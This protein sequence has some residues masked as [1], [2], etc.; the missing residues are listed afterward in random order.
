MKNSSRPYGQQLDTVLDSL[1]DGFCVFDREWRVL[2][3]NAPGEELLGRKVHDIQGK[4]FWKEFPTI[5]N[6]PFHL[7]CL[8]AAESQVKAEYEHYYSRTEKWFEINIYPAPESTTVYARDISRRK[9]VELANRQLVSQLERERT[10]LQTI[11][12]LLPIAVAVVEAPSGKL[13]YGNEQVSRIWRTPLQ[14]PAAIEEFTGWEGFHPDGSRYQ[15]DEWPL[16][17]SIK[18]GEVVSNEELEIR[19]GDG[20]RGVVSMNS[21]PIYGPM[22]NE[23]DKSIIGGIVTFYD[24]TESR[25]TKERLQEETETLETINR[26]GQMVSAELDLQKLVQAVTDAATELSGA[27]FGAFFYNVIDSKGEHY[28][29]YTLSGVPR[30]A[31]SQFPMPRSTDIF[32]HT[33]NGTGIVRSD[34]IM[35]DPRYGKMAPYY[36][37]PPGHLPVRSYLAVPVM[38]RSG[39]VLGGLFFGHSKVGVFTERV[40]RIVAGAAAQ[41]A[42]A[43]DNARLFESVIHERHAA[44]EARHVAE[45]ASRTKDEFLAVVSHELRTPLNAIVGWANMLNSGKLDAET[46]LQAQEIIERNAK[47]QAQ[48]IDDLLDVSRIMTGN[49]RMDTQPV[50]LRPVLEAALNAVRPAAEAKNIQ[51][52]LI[53]EPWTGPVLGDATRLQQVIWNLLSNAVKFTPKQGRI[54][55]HLK[56]VNSQICI[57]VKDSGEGIS[58]EFLP[59]VFDRFRQADGAATRRHNGLGLGLSIVRHI[60]EL[61]GGTVEAHS[62]G[63]GQGTTITVNLPLLAINPA[64]VN[65][66]DSADSSQSE[67]KGA[68]HPAY[69]G[70]AASEKTSFVSALAG[71]KVLVVEDEPDSRFM[72]RAALEGA[73]ME[74]RTA[75]S[76]AQAME[77]L[78]VWLPD[79]V[80]SDIGMPQEDGYALISKIRDLKPEQG[81]TVPAIALTAYV[82]AEDQAR[83]LSAGF[84]QHLAK[85]VDA[86]K[87]FETISSVLAE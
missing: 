73:K 70:E 62:E 36:G 77:V 75:E 26:L 1:T 72:I 81:G 39:E 12:H 16:L 30:E 35:Q 78:G 34:D 37:M 3:M 79:I 29:L 84:Q 25:Q 13:I 21:T 32:S 48:L 41:T 9:K 54:E 87:L 56:T 68:S 50:Q 27:Q 61:H 40:E 19:R 66:L 58:S 57:T 23:V 60:V 67:S 11:L 33:F 5:A 86:D 74:V 14:Q 43:M 63:E 71:I 18:Y 6:R 20:T 64:S 82:R 55:V 42:V 7:A 47:A 10:H 22:H 17:R 31:F 8:Q 44:E 53:M 46:T 65:A 45:E 76:V 85:P 69:L 83:A 4:I 15:L 28:T 38:S 59:Y 51:V 80:V 49:L 24:L 52:Q 2:Y